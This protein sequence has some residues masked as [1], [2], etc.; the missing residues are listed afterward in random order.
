M[1]RFTPDKDLNCIKV[2]IPRSDGKTLPALVL[3]PKGG[4]VG[5]PGI[6]WIHGGGYVSGMKEMVHMSRA[7]DLVKKYGATVISPGYRLSFA[8]PF[9]AA[10]NDCYDALVY[11][12][13]NAGTYGYNR[14][15]LMVGGESAGGG[16]CAALCMMARDKKEINIAYQMP[17]YP[18]LD[19][20]DTESSKD[21]HGKVW[22]TR[23]NH[24]AW[25][26]YLRKHAHEVVSPYAAPSR[27]EDYSKLPPAYSF[28]GDG[29]PFYSETC[30]YV[31][32]LN[33]AGVYAQ[34]DIYHSNVHAFDMTQPESELGRLAIEKF[35]EHF[36]YA[37]EN[38]FA[39]NK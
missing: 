34:I 31:E 13:N 1:Y 21:N 12:K 19:N 4:C 32:R 5:G 36:E 26:L 38:F 2:R 3:T 39:E 23:K 16:L 29:E 35:N 6:L 18:M 37:K 25:R 8:K 7:V 20:F 17:L 10:I 28:V 11:L 30:S 27:Q 22:N 14:N 33:E 9:P 15:Q 24:M